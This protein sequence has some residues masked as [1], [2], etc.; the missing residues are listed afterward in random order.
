MKSNYLILFLFAILSNETLR[1]QDAYF[2]I[3]PTLS[4]DGKVIVFSYDGDLWKIPSTGGEALRLTGMDGNETLPRISPDG[5]WIAFSS[6]QFG[7]V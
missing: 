3:D 2:Q 4:P 6:T 1:A 5:Q 7:N